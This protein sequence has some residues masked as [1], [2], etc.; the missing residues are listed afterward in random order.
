MD[1]HDL[2]EL[3]VQ[4][5]RRV[6]DFLHAVH[7]ANGA[8]PAR[9]LRED[10]CGTA[11]VACRWIQRARERAEPARAI[12]VDL[13]GPTL[14]AARTRARAEGVLD[15]LDLRRIDAVASPDADPA[16]VVFVGNFSIGEIHRRADLLTYFRRSLARLHAGGAGWGWGGGGVMVVDTY[17]GA[18]AFTL[19]TLNRTHIGKRG[20]VVHYTWEHVAA[21]PTTGMVENAIHFRVV[22]QGELVLALPNAYT[23]RWRLWSIA[24]LREAMTEAGFSA[25][26]VHT[27]VDLPPGVIP[28][29]V[30]DPGE[31]GKDWIACVVGRA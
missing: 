8:A 9:I 7:A 22:E 24:E 28:T 14:D 12:G 2:Y 13:D 10:F 29:P 25:T 31:L 19:G 6:V 26:E 27:K 15:A 5:P 4:S 16:D 21:D 23:Y 17:G 3:C 20:E 1:R 30:T 18:G 11:A